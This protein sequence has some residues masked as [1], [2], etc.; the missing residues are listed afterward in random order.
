MQLGQRR[1]EHAA[2]AGMQERCGPH[3]ATRSA[4]GSRPL[5]TP[6][7]LQH[8]FQVGTFSCEDS[9]LACSHCM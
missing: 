3:T 7:E 1:R 4:A 2:N 8:L 5:L 6:E 9:Q